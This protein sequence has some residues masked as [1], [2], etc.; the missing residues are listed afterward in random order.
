MLVSQKGKVG[1]SVVISVGIGY[2][3]LEG[4]PLGEN[5]FGS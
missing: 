3:N 5:L 4:Y 1:F 2:D